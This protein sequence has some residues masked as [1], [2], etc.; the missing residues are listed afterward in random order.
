MGKSRAAFRLRFVVSS[1]TSS[2]GQETGEDSVSHKTPRNLRESFWGGGAD[3]TDPRDYISHNTTREC[4]AIQTTTPSELCD[5][6][7][8]NPSKG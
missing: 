2:Q 3:E 5:R 7:G 6:P 8:S 1:S 4:S